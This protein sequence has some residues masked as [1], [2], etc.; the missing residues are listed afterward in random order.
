[1]KG[2]TCNKYEKCVA[3][4]LFNEKEVKD[5]PCAL[6]D[7]HGHYQIDSPEKPIEEYNCVVTHKKCAIYFSISVVEDESNKKQKLQRTIFIKN[8][9]KKKGN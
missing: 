2:E 9:S 6:C 4:K 1:M 5:S 8:L 7:Q 3:C